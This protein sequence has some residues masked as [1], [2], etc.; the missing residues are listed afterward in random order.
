M[1][2]SKLPDS[3]QKIWCYNNEITSLPENLPDSLQIIDCSYNQTSKL[4]ERLQNLLEKIDCSANQ[5]T[6]IYCKDLKELTNFRRFICYG[7]NLEDVSLP[8]LKRDCFVCDNKD[9]V[10]MKSL[11]ELIRRRIKIFLKLILRCGICKILIDNNF[12]DFNDCS[13]IIAQYI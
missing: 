12:N 13:F 6:K 4:P 9:E 8:L 7:N 5:I 2:I 10:I 1:Q 3:L 11:K